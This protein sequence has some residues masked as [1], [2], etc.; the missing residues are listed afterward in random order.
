MDKIKKSV[1]KQKYATV[2]ANYLSDIG[3]S[4]VAALFPCEKDLCR[5]KVLAGSTCGERGIAVIEWRGSNLEIFS[6]YLT[7]YELSEP[8]TE[9]E[10]SMI[11]MLGYKIQE[12]KK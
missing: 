5:V 3:A 6:E 2:S 11:G 10:K 8:M 4:A 12:L 1:R 7:I 9:E